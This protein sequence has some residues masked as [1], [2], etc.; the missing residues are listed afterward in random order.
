MKNI[1]IILLAM[2]A[3]FILIACNDSSEIETDGDEELAEMDDLEAELETE[4]EE[5]LNPWL[6]P[7]PASSL[8]FERPV[9][10]PSG[11][12][13]NAQEI[14]DFTSKLTEFYKQS[15]YF[16]WVWRIS[17]GMD[18]SYDADMMDYKLWWQDVGMRKE[19]DKVVFFHRGIAENI[20]ERTMKMLP[21]LIGGY[22]LTAD[23]RMANTAIQYMKGM[24]ALSKGMEFERE[25][26]L[27]KYL[28]SRSVF[29]HNHSYVVD[30]RKIEIDYSASKVASA[31]WNVH[32]FNIPDNPEYGDIWIANMRSKDDIPY[33]YQSMVMAARAYYESDNEE[34]RATALL[35]MEYI[36]GFCQSV[37]D[38]DW[39]I[40]T[41]YDDGEAVKMYDIDKET[42]PEADLGSFVHWALVFGEKAECNAQLGAGLTAYGNSYEF[43]DCEMGLGGSLFENYVFAIH[44]FNYE[45]YNHFHIGAMAAATLWGK[46]EIAENLMIGMVDRFDRLMHDESISH[47]DDPDFDSAM[48]GWLLVA[49]THG[50]PLT[51]DEAHHI[52]E[53]YTRSSDWYLKWPHWDPWNSLEDGESLYN[54]KAPRTETIVSESGDEI[55]TGYIRLMEMPY[56]FEYCASKLRDKDGVQFVN[57]DV[58]S[59]KAQWGLA[60]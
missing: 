25:N 4:I 16:D 48:A 28:Q 15:G 11:V 36:R 2:L 58:I 50:Y 57:C 59:D 33:M 31:K 51:A 24:V 19:G 23:E 12:D 10:E 13:P 54:D 26:P 8:G 30:D 3:S 47:R 21:N 5:D 60:R 7:R 14:T 38:N 44:F 49:A 40:L 41:K 29:N 39:Y 17:H 37:V 27:V 32:V 20:A 22:L 43:G 35:Y 18:K 56:I 1:S 6:P 46:T 42:R 9:R 55:K 52:M 53:W 45:I 34:L